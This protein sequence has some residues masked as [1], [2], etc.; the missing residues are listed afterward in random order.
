MW[1]NLAVKHVSSHEYFV[2]KHYYQT[3]GRKYHSRSANILMFLDQG[4]GTCGPRAKYGPREHLKWPTSEFSLP[5][6][7]HTRVYNPEPD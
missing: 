3:N 7:E 2:R 1:K 6:W 5:K 4:W